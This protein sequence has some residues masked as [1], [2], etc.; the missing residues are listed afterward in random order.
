MSII[1]KNKNNNTTQN[2]FSTAT[3][4]NN[5]I[6]LLDQGL[7]INS[8]YNSN[9]FYQLNVSGN[10]NFTG[11]LFQNDV[12]FS[13]P[14]TSNIANI[15]RYLFSDPYLIGANFIPTT[16]SKYS[17]GNITNTWGS[18][19]IG[20]GNVNVGNGNINISN[21]SIKI[22]NST[23]SSIGSNINLN[24]STNITGNLFVSENINIV[25]NIYNNGNIF[26][27]PTGPSGVTKALPT[28]SY[29]VSS[30]ITIVS[31]IPT[32]VIFDKFDNLNSSGTGE[33]RYNP[34]TGILINPTSEIMTICISGQIQTDNESFDVT[35]NQP[36]IYLVKNNN[37]IISSSVLNYGGSSFSTTLV[38][39]PNDQIK[40]M[41]AQYFNTNLNIEAG[42]YVTRITY[43]QLNNILSYTGYTGST[44]PAGVAFALPSSSYY[45]SGNVSIPSLQNTTIVFNTYDSV[46][47]TGTTDFA[48]DVGTGILTNVTNNVMTLLI[49]G[50]FQTD[51]SSFDVTQDQPVIYVVKNSNNIISSSVLNYQGSS[52]TTTLILNPSDAVRITFKQY[53]SNPI[54]ILGGQFITRVT[55]TQLNNVVARTGSTGPTG[56]TGPAGNELA[57][58]SSSYYLSSN[59]NVLPLQSTTILYNILDEINSNGVVTYTYNTGS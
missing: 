2:I 11:Q 19:Y 43:T 44:G 31:G 59:I 33:F 7:K 56:L 36:T 21:G 1:Y 8:I 34:T 47:S 46:N 13:S 20:N 30:N 38:L 49:A 5:N 52:F 16:N 57:L 41:F 14:I 40:V 53:F 23:I 22:G 3:I 45:L 29:Y 4:P 55:Y 35:Q 37:N 27:G 12:P 6:L 58:P 50:Q 10:I 48:Y 39:Y 24:K 26:Q 25:G 9:I 17:L 51:N 18:L 54:N 32:L 15:Y 42:Q 28:S